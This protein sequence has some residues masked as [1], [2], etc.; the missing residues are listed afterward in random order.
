MLDGNDVSGPGIG[1]SAVFTVR[2]E[3]AELRRAKHE[4]A[5]R[6]WHRELSE[7]LAR[8]RELRRESGRLIPEKPREDQESH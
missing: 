1:S 6:E 3:D 4:E 5:L 8:Q 7:I 2:I